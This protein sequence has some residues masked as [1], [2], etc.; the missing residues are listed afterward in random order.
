MAQTML[1]IADYAQKVPC[2]GSR[3]VHTMGTYWELAQ[4]DQVQ[5]L[6][7]PSFLNLVH[8]DECYRGQACMYQCLQKVFENHLR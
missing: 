5:Q 8:S 7:C 2:R 3:T 6:E 1:L 4:N